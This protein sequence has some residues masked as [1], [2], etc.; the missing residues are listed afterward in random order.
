MLWRAGPI[1]MVGKTNYPHHNGGVVHHNLI[2]VW[3]ARLLCTTK[4]YHIA[5]HNFWFMVGDMEGYGWR[6][7]SLWW[8]GPLKLWRA[9]RNYPH[10]KYHHNGGT[11]H[12]NHRRVWWARLLCTP[13]IDH[14]AHHNF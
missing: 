5:R 12:H 7:G 1:N 8:V 13:K 3:W 4:I 2:R 11:A 6:H 9:K 10:H 14:I